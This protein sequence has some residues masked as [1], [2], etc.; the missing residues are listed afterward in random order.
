MALPAASAMEPLHLGQGRSDQP[1]DPVNL[2][3]GARSTATGPGPRFGMNGF[4]PPPVPQAMQLDPG[5]MVHRSEML[6]D[7]AESLLQ[8]NSDLVNRTENLMKG[9][10]RLEKSARESSNDSLQSAALAKKCLEETESVFNKTRIEARKVEAEMKRDAYAEGL[11]SLTAEVRKEDSQE[12]SE[13]LNELRNQVAAMAARVDFLEKRI[14][15]LDNRTLGE[16]RV[17]SR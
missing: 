1:A 14:A 8:E 17:M 10:E 15:E 11:G 12:D 4:A 2:D 7:E 13:D 6:V 5:F 16:K 3:L 9:V